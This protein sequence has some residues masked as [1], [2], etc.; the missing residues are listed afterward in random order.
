VT[1]IHYFLRYLQRENFETNNTLLLLNRLCN[2]NRL[3]F[4]RFLSELLRDAATDAG[5]AIMLG[6]QIK[7]QVGTGGSIVDG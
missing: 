2:Y 4:E 6:L 1:Q 3:R 7:Q 5:S